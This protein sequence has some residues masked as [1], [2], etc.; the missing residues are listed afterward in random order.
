MIDCVLV[1]G[2]SRNIGRSICERLSADDYTVVQFDVIA[3]EKTGSAEYAR[4]DLGD[5]AAV[6]LEEL[7]ARY[8][9]TR[10]VNNVGIFSIAPIVQA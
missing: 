7:A 3:P 5:E 1:T 2:G 10:L 6:A 8:R 4:V 9:V